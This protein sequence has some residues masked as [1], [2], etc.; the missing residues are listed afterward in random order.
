MM[1]D[2]PGFGSALDDALPAVKRY[3]RIESDAE[4]TLVA[5]LA[6]AAAR[7]AEAF[8][9]LVLVQRSFAETLYPGPEWRRLSRTPVTAITTVEGLDLAGAPVALPVDGHAIDIDADGDGWVRVTQPDGATRI[10]VHYVAGLASEWSALP[11][12]IRQGV[13]RLA[14]HL[15]R[16][17]DAADDRGPP[18]AV[19][20][21]LRPWRRMPFR[22]AR[23][24]A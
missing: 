22:L 16:H 3:A 23:H 24:R 7:T 21:L 11:E 5:E 20:A 2:D 1:I 17:R 8:L 6:N 19:A 12:T 10:R 14:T 13:I 15:H 4:D 18:V 9:G